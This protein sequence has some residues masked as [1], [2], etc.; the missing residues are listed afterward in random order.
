M[1]IMECSNSRSIWP[2]L[3]L[4]GSLSCIEAKDHAREEKKPV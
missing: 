2:E 1:V 4:E 3:D